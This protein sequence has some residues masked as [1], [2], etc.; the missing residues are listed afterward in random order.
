MYSWSGRC[1][2]PSI[3][4]DGA[5]DDDDDDDDEEKKR[6][7]VM[8]ALYQWRW[9]SGR[10]VEADPTASEARRTV[11]VPNPELEGCCWDVVGCRQGRS[12]HANKEDSNFA[13]S[14]VEKLER[15]RGSS[16]IFIVDGQPAKGL[17]S[18]AN[19]RR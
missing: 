12:R 2:G 19:F 7:L 10:W 14:L 15:A 8:L 5:V 16:G 17:P 3:D 4:D 13:I 18:N 9:P 6:R 1:W 11:G